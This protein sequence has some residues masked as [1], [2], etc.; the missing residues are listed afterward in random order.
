MADN[1]HEVISVVDSV[2]TDIPT[3]RAA[4]AELK[5][6]DIGVA[7]KRILTMANYLGKGW[8]AIL[9]ADN[10]SRVTNIPEFILE[11]VLGACEE[12][13]RKTKLKILKHRLVTLT[14]EGYYEEFYDQAIQA[15]SLLA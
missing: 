15:Q 2:Y 11:A 7:G 12:L 3:R 8:F 6:A 9:L 4:K 14:T 1:T 5:D 10:I 13:P